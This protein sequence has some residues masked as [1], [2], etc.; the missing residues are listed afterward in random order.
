MSDVYIKYF[1]Y[2]FLLPFRPLLGVL[3]D[4]CICERERAHGREHYI[5]IH[6]EY[7][8]PGIRYSVHEGKFSWMLTSFVVC[9]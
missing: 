4:V 5:T 6:T 8:I 2:D 1:F 9:R 3:V 7:R